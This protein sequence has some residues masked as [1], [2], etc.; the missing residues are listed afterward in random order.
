MPDNTVPC[1]RCYVAQLVVANDGRVIGFGLG[2]ASK[3]P[4]KDVTLCE[5][6]CDE[7][8]VTHDLD[9]NGEYPGAFA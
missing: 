1:G 8:I 6:C 9:E 5:P 3:S 4:W 2:T 7:E